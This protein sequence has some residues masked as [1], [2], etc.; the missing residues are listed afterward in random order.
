MNPSS[1]SIST[2][3]HRKIIIPLLLG[4][5][6]FIPIVATAQE[7]TEEPQVDTVET[8]E[9]VEES[10]PVEEPVAPT[11][12][13]VVEP[14]QPVVEEPP[15]PT[16]EPAVEIEQPVVEES[17]E[18]TEEPAVEEEVV[19]EETVAET[20]VPVEETS[21][22]EEAAP[23]QSIEGEAVEETLEED[24]LVEATEEPAVE[25][26]EPEAPIETDV[27]EEPEA[28]PAPEIVEVEAV[29]V[30]E[31][32]SISEDFETFTGESWIAADWT[33]AQVDESLALVSIIAG[34]TAE[35]TSVDWT[36]YTITVDV[37]V[38]ADNSLA[39]N[40][41]GHSLIMAS[42]GSHQLLR[43]GEVVAE[44]AF[45]VE[46]TEAEPTPPTWHT[47]TI[48]KTETSTTILVDEIPQYGYQT[49]ISPLGIF[50]FVATGEQGVAIDNV[51]MAEVE[52]VEEIVETP[53]PE[54]IIEAETTEEPELLAEATEEPAIVAEA[55]EEPTVEEEVV[56]EV[57]EV[58][59]DAPVY[60]VTN[61]LTEDFEGDLSAWTTSASIVE[62]AEGNHVLL[63][64]SDGQLAP[65][66]ASTATNLSISGEANIVSDTDVAGSFTVVVG[67]GYS[68]EISTTGVAINYNGEIVAVAES[69]QAIS[70]WFTFAIEADETGI[71]V[72]TN[73]VV[74]TEFA[75]ESI[76]SGSF[77]LTTNTSTMLDNLSVDTLTLEEVEEIVEVAA[78][79]A[80]EV[81]NTDILNSLGGIAYDVMNAYFE[82]GDDAVTALLAESSDPQDEYG[83]VLV[84]ILVTNGYT[85]EAIGQI[86]TDA[87][88]EVNRV[89]DESLEAY[90]S[91]SALLAVGNHEGVLFI[92]DIIRAVSTGPTAPIGTNV[93]GNTWT[94][95]FNLLSIEEWNDAGVTGNGVAIG[96]IDTGFE[97]ANSGSR[98]GNLAC[99]ANNSI[100][101]APGGSSALFDGNAP[102]VTR[103]HG[104]QAI[105][106]IC[107]IAPQA[108]VYMYR[109]DD[110]MSL[111]N[112]IN[113]ATIGGMDVILITLDLGVHTSAGGGEGTTSNDIY[114][115]LET[116]KNAGIVP[117]VAA[118][119]S[120]QRVLNLHI[121][122]ADDGKTFT[123]NL[124]VT[125]DD[126]I[127]F[128][129]NDFAGNNIARV[130]A[131]LTYNST[132][133]NG[134]STN[135]LLNP[136]TL[137][138][139]G[140]DDNASL[141][142]T[143]NHLAGAD[144]YLQIQISPRV[145]DI[146]NGNGPG[147]IAIADNDVKF[148]F[149]S[150][151]VN[152]GDA[153]ANDLTDTTGSLG[154][155]ADSDDVLSV[156]ASCVA[157]NAGPERWEFSSTG[158][159]FNADG[160]PQDV[161][162]DGVITQAEA[163]PSLMSYAFVTTFDN[164][165]APEVGPSGPIIA[166]PDG[167]LVCS[168]GF[169][170][171]SAAAAHV[172]G[173]TA[174]LMSNDSNSSFDAMNDANATTSA[175][176][177]AV[178]NYLQAR[179]V[180][181][182]LAN[183]DGFDTTYGS[184]LAVL[185]APSYDLS[186]AVNES[187]DADLLPDACQIGKT[188]YVGQGD[189]DNTVLDGTIAAPY[190]SIADAIEKGA[191]DV[192]GYD[193]I[194]VMPG[195]YVSPILVDTAHTTDLIVTGYDEVDTDDVADVVFW[196]RNMH[197]INDQDDVFKKR[198]GLYFTDQ[199]ANIEFRGF[200]FAVAD[201]LK[202]IDDQGTPE[203]SDDVATTFASSDVQAVVID[204]STDVTI[205]NS[206][207]GTISLNNEEY[208]G[209]TDLTGT[210]IL[211]INDT[212][213][214]RIENNIFN[215]NNVGT[216]QN[217]YPTMAIVNSGGDS[218]RDPTNDNPIVVI[219][220]EIYNN[221]VRRNDTANW[222][223]VLYAQGSAV[224][225]INNAFYDNT[226]DTII[227]IETDD[228]R[229]PVDNTHRRRARIVG[230]VFLNNT[231]VAAQGQAGSLINGYYAP[232]MYIVNNTFVG[233]TVGSNEVGFG[234]LFS[235]G[236][237][238]ADSNT[239]S[240]A[241]GWNFW[242]IHNNLIYNNTYRELVGD[243]GDVA[244]GGTCHRIPNFD[245]DAD[246]D[247][248]DY[249]GGIGERYNV[250][251]DGTD[252]FDQRGAQNNWIVDNTTVSAEF[253]DCTIAIETTKNT[254][255]TPAFNN[256]NII[257]ADQQPV[258]TRDEDD[259]AV[260][261]S[262]NGDFQGLD[263]DGSVFAATDWQYYALTQTYVNAVD[264]DK[265]E[266]SDGIDAAQTKWLSPDADGIAEGQPGDTSNPYMD[267]ADVGSDIV[268]TAR[269][270]DV[271]N[272]VINW[273]SD[274]ADEYDY[275]AAPSPVQG[276]SSTVTDDYR[277]RYL[278]DIGAFEFSPLQFVT[279][280]QDPD[281]Y[282]A[283]DEI[284]V[285]GNPPLPAVTNGL[286]E[287][288]G[289]VQFDIST[290]VTGGFGEL[291][292][293]IPE[294][295]Q[296]NNFGTHCGAQFEGTRGLVSL[297]GGASN[298]F[299]YC[300]PADYYT[301][302]G[303]YVSFKIR[304]SDEAGATTIGEIRFT[305]DAVDDAGFDDDTSVAIGDE[306]PD[307]NDTFEVV[308]TLGST[309]NARL[310]PYV[311]FDNFFFS[312][313]GNA[314][315][316][317]SGS[318]FIDYPFTYEITNVDDPDGILIGTIQAGYTDGAPNGDPI[319][320]FI[321]S[322]A[323][324]GV[325]TIT[326]SV[327]DAN[328]EESD[329]NILKVRSAS[330]IPTEGLFDDTSFVWNYSDDTNSVFYTER[331]NFATTDV[332]QSG[333]WQSLRQNGAINNTIHRTS[334]VGDTATFRFVGT[335]FTLYMREGS[336]S[337]SHF[338]LNIYDDVTTIFSSTDNTETWGPVPGS[339]LVN[340]L[341]V[342]SDLTCTT[343]AA[344]DPTDGQRLLHSLGNYTITCNGLTVRKHTVQVV[345]TG[346]RLLSVDAF[347]IINDG[348]DFTDADP[349]PPGFYDIDNGI[350]RNA[351]DTEWEETAASRFS[352][353][354]ALEAVAL[355]KNISFTITEATG[356]AIGSTY[357]NTATSYEIC[358]DDDKI[359]DA[360]EGICQ[361]IEDN[362]DNAA[363]NSIHHPFFGLN[364]DNNY[365][366]TLK[367]DASNNG[368]IFDNLVVFDSSL[369]P[370]NSLP[371]GITT[372]DNTDITFGEPFGND[373][374]QAGS[375]QVIQGGRSSIGPFFAF[376]IDNNID[377]LLLNV[378]NIIPP[379]PCS[380]KDAKRG[381]CLPAPP[382]GVQG[383]MV[384]VN[385]G[386]QAE[387]TGDDEGNCITV[388]T[389]T[390]TYTSVSGTASLDVLPDRSIVIDETLFPQAW[391]QSPNTIEVFGMRNNSRLRFN[392]V[393]LLS[394]T[395][396]LGAGTYQSYSSGINFLDY[397]PT[398]TPAYDVV[399][400]GQV[401]DSW[402]NRTITQC[403]RF[404][405]GVCTD[406]RVV[407]TRLETRGVGDGIL[408]KMQGTGFEPN[409]R[410]SGGQRLRACWLPESQVSSTVEGD[411]AQEIQSEAYLNGG[412]WTFDNNTV[413]RKQ[414]VYGLAED[415]YWVMV[416]L[417]PS[418]TNRSTSASLQNIEVLDNSWESLTPISSTEG[419]IEASYD[420]RVAD[421]RFE[422]IGSWSTRANSNGARSGVSYDISSSARGNGVMFRT[423]GGNNVQI[424]RDLRSTQTFPCSSRDS[425]RGLCRP[426]IAGYSNMAVCFAPESNPDSQTCAVYSNAGSGSQAALSISLPDNG[427]Y[428]FSITSISNSPF[429]IDAFEVTDSSTEKMVEG[430]YQEDSTLIT[431]SSG[432]ESILKSIGFENNDLLDTA[433]GTWSWNIAN[434]VVG[435]IV[436]ELR[437]S[438]S[439][440]AKIEANTN[441]TLDSE[442][443]QLIAGET[444]TVVA[445]VYVLTDDTSVSLDLTG[446][447]T[448]ATQETQSTKRWELVRH[449]FTATTSEMAQ[450][451]FTA[452]DVTTFYVDN[453]NVYRGSGSWTL[454][455]GGLTDRRI[456]RSSG[457]NATASFQFT[458]TGF[459][460][461]LSSNTA[462]GNVAVCYDT[463]ADMSTASCFTY[464]DR[465]PTPPTICSGRGRR[466]VCFPAF[467]A[468]VNN[469]HSAVG[470]PLN[471]YY[472]TI[473]EAGD[474]RRIDLDYVQ[475]YNNA[476]PPV[477]DA[478]SYNED[479]LIGNEP[480][481][482]LFPPENWSQTVNANGFTER[483]YYR[484][485]GA[486]VGSGIALKVA[487][488]EPTTIVIDINRPRGGANR[489]L[490]CI[491]DIVGEFDSITGAVT[492]N[493]CVLMTQATS[494]TQLV[495]NED[496]L[497]LLDGLGT[498][499]LFT[500]QSL[501]RNNVFIDNYQIILGT[502]LAE[503]FYQDTLGSTLLQVS[504]NVSATTPEWRTITNGRFSGRTA[505]LTTTDGATF[506]FTF[507]GTGMSLLPSTGLPQTICTSF[508]RGVCR[509]TTVVTPP[510]GN[511]SIDISTV[512]GICNGTCAQEIPELATLGVTANRFTTIA[513]LPYDTYTVTLTAE[514]T[515]NQQISVDG[516]EIYGDL[517]E[518]GSLYDDAQTN[519]SGTQL[520]SFGPQNADW[521]A[522]TGA[523]TKY[524]NRTYHQSTRQGATVS[525]SVGAD[526][527][528]RGIV[529]YD[530]N[531]NTPLVDV[532]WSNVSNTTLTRS[533]Q[534]VILSDGEPATTVD[535][536]PAGAYNISITSKQN[537]RPF[538]IDAVQILEDGII[539][540]GIFEEDFLVANGAGTGTS[541]V[542]NSR[543][544][545][546]FVMQLDQGQYYKF[547]FEGV[548]FSTQ[549][550]ENS[551]NYTICAYPGDTADTDCTNSPAMIDTI[552]S[553]LTNNL[554]ALSY[555]GF[556]Q[557]GAENSDGTWT[558][559]IVNND[560]DDP[561]YIDRIDV[562]SNNN[563]LFIDDT[564]TYEAGD[565]QIRYLPFGSWTENSSFKAS[566]PLN[567][568][569]FETRLPGAITYFEFGSSTFGIEYIRQMRKAVPGR[570]ICL[571]R[572]CRRTSFIPPVA[573]YANANVCY[574]ALGDPNLSNMTCESFDNSSANL[575]QFASS[576][577][578]VDC[579]NG[580][581]GYIQYD[582]DSIANSRTTLDYVRLYD[583]ASTLAQG[584][585]QENH[586]N[587]VYSI[588]GT[589][590]ANNKAEV[591]F[592]NQIDSS[593]ADQFVAFP[594]VGTGFSVRTL[595]GTE[596]E[597]ISLCVYDYT[598]QGSIPNAQ[599][600]I[601]NGD[602]NCMR[603]YDQ[604]FRDGTFTERALHGLHHGAEYLG[605]IKM[606]ADGNAETTQLN[607]DQITIF[608]DQW[609]TDTN[610]DDATYLNE[611][612]GGQS[613][614]I[615]FK[616]RDTDKLVQF[617][618]DNWSTVSFRVQ[619]GC[620]DRKCRQPIFQ[621][622]TSDRGTGSGTTALFRTDNA[623]ALT[624][625]VFVNGTG[626]VQICAIPLQNTSTPYQVDLTQSVNCQTT[627]VQRNATLGI[628]FNDTQAEEHVITVELVTPRETFQRTVCVSFKRNTCRAFGVQTST[629][630]P[631]MRIDNI[632][633]FDV[634]Q[635]LAEGRYD[636]SFPG[637]QFDTNYD[638]V[639]SDS[640]EGTLYWNNIGGATQR[641][642][643][644]PV[645]C[646]SKQIRRGQC[647]PSEPRFDGS[648]ALRVVADPG[649]GVEFVDADSNGVDLQPDTYYTVSAYVRNNSNNGS[650]VTLQLIKNGNLL[651]ELNGIDLS[652]SSAGRWQ[653][654]RTTF[655]TG[656]VAS[657]YENVTLRLV[658]GG[659][660][661]SFFLDRV[662]LT[663]GAEWQTINAS[664]S[665]LGGNIYRSSTPGASFSFTFVGTGFE[666]GLLAGPRSGE[667]KVCYEQ[668]GNVDPNAVNC[669]TYDQ[670]NSSNSIYGR[671]IVGL[672]SA[673]WVV[674]VREM[675]DGYRTTSTSARG[676]GELFALDYI[677]IY[678]DTDIVSVPVG[679][680]NEDAADGSDNQYLTLYP[681]DKWRVFSGNNSYSDNSY[682]APA[683]G[684]REDRQ[685]GPTAVLQVD[686]TSPDE[687]WAVV[688]QLGQ[689]S[690]NL[691]NSAL[692]C[693]NE[694]NGVMTWSDGEYI[695]ENSDNCKIVNNLTQDKQITVSATEFSD[696]TQ[697][698]THTISISSLSRDGASRL[699]TV[700]T[701]FKRGKCR[702]TAQVRQASPAILRIDGYQV[703]NNQVLSPGFY[704][705]LLP[706]TL[707][708]F[709]GGLDTA[710]SCDETT[711]WCQ[712][713]R[714][715][716]QQTVCISSRRGTC[717]AF[718]VR[719]VGVRPYIGSAA[720]TSQE[721]ASIEFTM[722]GTGFS[723]ISDVWN[724]GLDFRVCYRL[725]TSG[726]SFPTVGSGEEQF[727]L[728]GYDNAGLPIL[729]SEG[730]ILCENMTTDTSNW[731]S[732]MDRPNRGGS[733]YG[734]SFYGM[735]FTTY[736]VQIV[737]TT[738]QAEISSSESFAF[739]GLQIF[740]DVST[741]EVLQPGFT[742]NTS[743]NII[744][745][746]S[747]FWDSN[748]RNGAFQNTES[749]T[750]NAG[751]IAQYRINGNSVVIYQRVGNM[752]SDVQVCVVIS[753]DNIHCSVE[754]ERQTRIARQVTSYTQRGQSTSRTVCVRFRGSSCR[755][756]STI[757]VLENTPF[758]PVVFYGLGEDQEH[759]IIMENRENTR[760]FNL[761]AIR[762][763]E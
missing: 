469:A 388:N 215:D 584:V 251:D 650:N 295:G 446:L 299:Q 668:E 695:V 553:T 124:G 48:N 562:L 137:T 200:T 86:V 185:G 408:F 748:S 459:T 167:S 56:E 719:T 47:V 749:V 97:G 569:Q 74:V 184:G 368:L 527:P 297:G 677:N 373:W 291:S 256:Q 642:S 673:T 361:T 536:T 727:A 406:L 247:A 178:R 79:P 52:I 743:E 526:H 131:T 675:D 156:G 424:I 339:D 604:E 40:F 148:D 237:K 17:T 159:R 482:Q 637:I 372:A 261:G 537:G 276:I 752:T 16:E 186:Q 60:T 437:R 407:G 211:I 26:V 122:V 742:D 587:I 155:P 523:N 322:N 18:S 351:F 461:N 147:A 756:F 715:F 259:I 539:T 592:Y 223:A 182:P 331:T 354:I 64:G 195:E 508:K 606:V 204:G 324:S 166:N 533:C 294:D 588:T 68:V 352:N 21:T 492:S 252:E 621:T 189:L 627:T 33:V 713:D 520:L 282:D 557:T 476:A 353:G 563:E 69:A 1:D 135:P 194:V 733:Q 344:V 119:N 400:I 75:G 85:G 49:E 265:N 432:N 683:N 558:V 610:L 656:S 745:E 3:A 303:D 154:R 169:G 599:T 134:F 479:A 23:E 387:S 174:L 718:G 362:V 227:K 397:V 619:T 423:T 669:F 277:D 612:Q 198:A 659:N 502:T 729:V 95:A 132:P 13:P 356:F 488:D 444:Y 192:A 29:V 96:V 173:M 740:S 232:F 63:M 224:D 450:L 161:T 466:Q 632:E 363:R 697:V 81:T 359:L 447:N 581:W 307:A 109:A 465:Q 478:G 535:I 657:D 707:L 556:T 602:E 5:L 684:T 440:S 210:P 725:N 284:T 176:F 572:K 603:T 238:G 312:E 420:N 314:E 721:G 560:S 364:P 760:I 550:V 678:N 483:S 623:S 382:S 688:F 515:G 149:T 605:I 336:S 25:A 410:T 585:Y 142:V 662:T 58:V 426:P 522:V 317:D 687:T 371:L 27:A 583:P 319:R 452:N 340:E 693:V 495:F 737:V 197:F 422:Y 634:V 106:L 429:V 12:D 24:V 513:G 561:L 287:D 430:V 716:V 383:L 644:P 293:A 112:A 333:D 316:D 615:D 757:S 473:S 228:P 315:F 538:I 601:N 702:S 71:T 209:W 722:Q 229:N 532:C 518:L 390:N 701:S 54:I 207:F 398:N 140:E 94:E 638:E 758:T 89:Y 175:T 441:D 706:G 2:I 635:G 755:Q 235:R 306:S 222:D 73:D 510:V 734:F 88:G 541:P 150:L 462:S 616:T 19:T 714:K 474:N 421:N 631:W 269:P 157:T 573:A 285:N 730:S 690:S 395:L 667:V 61:L 305:I 443:F 613:Y 191:A 130:D 201:T 618:G 205:S 738:P 262:F 310:R 691:L 125:E 375:S 266:Y 763:I 506:E 704:D 626:D 593:N 128:S 453:V 245:G 335:G 433:V 62:V 70:T 153:S 436:T 735:P 203:T 617:V 77:A 98:G 724:N 107:D 467:S 320:E 480:G 250:G 641:K 391:N 579:T 633:L 628:I 703:F 20:D 102:S 258:D 208:V 45:I 139:G 146:E 120:N 393:Q 370:S 762:V 190:T 202:E 57:A 11:E 355:T 240:I 221:E 640:M 193:C 313:S 711:G 369:D 674:T 413:N 524:L 220:N 591:G 264:S 43:D 341:N 753:N 216:N 525:F 504:E 279:N 254:T 37:K 145:S 290:V 512:G 645:V 123:V 455:S 246:L 394:T 7:A 230:N 487:N 477:V 498:E 384:C 726:N 577:A 548:A 475:I 244:T 456:A 338:A 611:L 694:T 30:E 177:T 417:L 270:L 493:N 636:Q 34:A 225:I 233:N 736:D 425:K 136:F 586:P 180:D 534:E 427:N 133:T 401:S 6:L 647:P 309:L 489:L 529:I 661:T 448:F 92:R 129:W 739:D 552:T 750:N 8:V 399:E 712:N 160:T 241:D 414:G 486:P 296:P 67:E 507:E 101:S 332:P 115:L 649:D 652:T 14:E 509:S 163:K 731:D 519:V 31:V 46:A 457:Y 381:R 514:I 431:Y 679:A 685:P 41:D 330:V 231:T 625:D 415:I 144:V 418:N 470:L 500:L 325:A 257:D 165:P 51:A 411:I 271:N 530:G 288:P 547:V 681:E 396:G 171:T 218:D 419:R 403:F 44:P 682:V 113:A 217:I 454:R 517:Q 377:G 367:L 90:V 379:P 308:G 580:C 458:G 126:K 629:T 337:R 164:F 267:G 105:E 255:N 405:R 551:E 590:I 544:G 746:P 531:S 761:D 116:A 253:G 66:V 143:V 151:L 328:L 349:L 676:G 485:P 226:A 620:A 442:E 323:N 117:I 4:L 521:R 434:S 268:N 499:R 260:A 152:G 321:L 275:I 528:S 491:D 28:T 554:S 272:W 575:F 249:D 439:R 741:V 595:A 438:G 549:I 93:D 280:R 55:T 654:L 680:N 103:N 32:V 111:E 99:L 559:V 378:T 300:P 239:G 376:D 576:T 655:K 435:S 78:T 318:K 692:V 243:T 141:S 409:M 412:C 686:V 343:R 162:G 360:N 567:G 121:P 219:N 87:G 449:T 705:E 451:Q 699:V 212:Q 91:V 199:A 286:L 188:V 104:T 311:R 546:G 666:I 329:N 570:T 83:R 65:A 481:L 646:S 717:R 181:M 416:E 608:N 168:D 496:N 274:N 709:S 660:R 728:Q 72:S 10:T 664:Y 42:D 53:A 696:L 630:N 589:A 357:R 374:R 568:D 663:S 428:I 392:S 698:G 348:G 158:P 471:D 597:D 248:W 747:N 213:G 484:V 127:N 490:A 511:F 445:N 578:A 342:G 555:A 672:D 183:A 653:A 565:T 365:T 540:E 350:L 600:I 366:V 278:L 80:P 651:T 468:A 292:Y 665:Q 214:A 404:R 622:R 289:I 607:I 582:R 639:I 732:V 710:S 759:T 574:G 501:N 179:S 358:V 754:A 380:S 472:V 700:C 82:G 84:D 138:A 15:A 302:P 281:Y 283:D 708:N 9:A 723:I 114:T 497:P 385:R 39:L 35:V 187:T 347:A 50:A 503:G 614:P 118:G 304:I 494:Q 598:G 172:A 744:Y 100:Q 542:A 671:S 751:A 326:Y 389:R 206:Q 236:D 464:D 38:E 108:D 460:V 596:A 242:E 624:V 346:G 545:N 327:F 263:P 301:L 334:T 609:Y 273:D 36:S 196:L 643:L 345:N 59:E 670:D 689:Q 463:N 658:V 298:I 564:E 22:E 566:D 543:A 505:L 170:G 386:I 720:V 402:V 110:I 516:I 571:D 594:F 234:Q 648:R 76:V